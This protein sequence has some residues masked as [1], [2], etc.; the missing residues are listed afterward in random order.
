[1]RT[2]VQHGSKCKAV[3]YYLLAKTSLVF[4]SVDLNAFREPT[5]IIH[6]DEIELHQQSKVMFQV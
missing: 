3:N 6:L 4:N 2:Y 1:M 5:F